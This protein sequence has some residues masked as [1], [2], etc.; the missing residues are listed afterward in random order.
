MGRPQQ[1]AA[2]YSIR[3]PFVGALLA[4]NCCQSLHTFP[5]LNSQPCIY[6]RYWALF[7]SLVDT[8]VT[9]PLDRQGTAF[10]MRDATLSDP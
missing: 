2:A 1:S 7:I 10:L 6:S 4:G 3:I 5:L 8:Y 9:G